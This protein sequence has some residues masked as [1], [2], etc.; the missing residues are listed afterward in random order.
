MLDWSVDWKRLITNQA[1]LLGPIVRMGVRARVIN[2]GYRKLGVEVAEL[3]SQGQMQLI[4]CIGVV[5]GC[6]YQ[7]VGRICEKAT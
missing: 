2:N 7:L 6:Q 1:A 3:V 5:L 4:R